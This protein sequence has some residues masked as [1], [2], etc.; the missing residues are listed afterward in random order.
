VTLEHIIKFFLTRQPYQGCLAK[1]ATLSWNDFSAAGFTRTD[2]PLHD[3]LQFNTPLANTISAW[4]SHNTELTKKFKKTQ[5][6]LPPV[7]GS[8]EMIEEAFLDVLCDLVY[9]GGWLDLE[10]G[11]LLSVMQE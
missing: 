10:Q 9:G 2:A 5:R 4:S 6:E 8:E 1:H 3:T 11:K 7:M